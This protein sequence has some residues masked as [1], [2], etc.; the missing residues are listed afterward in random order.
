MA[1]ITISRGSFSKGKEIAE[2]LA[3]RLDYRCIS[4]D[5]LLEASKE[6]N[7]PDMKL[8]RAIHDAPSV[9]E[10]FTYGKERYIAFIRNELLEKIQDDNVIYHGLAGH[11][12]LKEIPNVMK[13]R[14]IA[15]METRIREEMKR[16][17]IKRFEAR[18]LLHKDDEERRKWSLSLYGI[19]TNDPKLYDLV[20]N[21]SSISVDDAVEILFNTAQMKCFQ[22][23]QK[24]K[25]AIE[26]QLLA[27]RIQSVLIEKYPTAKV[28]CRNGE[29]TV[30]I[31]APLLKE[32]KISEQVLKMI[33]KIPGIKEIKTMVNPFI[34]SD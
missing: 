9:L 25:Q 2:K 3:A 1:I 31:K 22:I 23:N 20:L 14:I 13:V 24:S 10:R 28:C 19:D 16:E 7:I 29:C 6:F 15:N 34:T 27:S 18:Y 4:R 26:D 5:I 11:F 30:S 12:L 8:V 17:N 33:R 32:K 21:I